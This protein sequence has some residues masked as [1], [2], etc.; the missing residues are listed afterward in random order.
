MPRPTRAATWSTDVPPIMELSAI[1]LVAA[2]LA[3]VV[4]RTTTRGR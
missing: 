4:D 3:L 1:C 2:L